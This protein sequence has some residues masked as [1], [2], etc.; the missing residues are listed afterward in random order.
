MNDVQLGMNDYVQIFFEMCIVSSKL[1]KY[2]ILIQLVPSPVPLWPL[3]VVSLPVFFV[4]AEPSPPGIW[5]WN[6]AMA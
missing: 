6:L 5:S 1:R 3:F 2:V 4:S